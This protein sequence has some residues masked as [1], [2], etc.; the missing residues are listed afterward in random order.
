[1]PS[2]RADKYM[3][4]SN[5]HVNQGSPLPGSAKADSVSGNEKGMLCSPKASLQ[6]SLMEKRR[7]QVALGST[8]FLNSF[9]TVNSWWFLFTG[10]RLPELVYFGSV[11]APSLT[12]VDSQAGVQF[13]P[14]SLWSQEKPSFQNIQETDQGIKQ[15][16][17]PCV[18]LSSPCASPE[19]PTSEPCPVLFSG[20]VPGA[21]LLILAKLS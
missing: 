15:N 16:N 12:L 13:C 20:P 8:H 2:L 6:L 5:C 1:M 9:C 7:S 17:L 18:H 4:Q 11:F 19:S 21:C 10:S 3:G 14:A